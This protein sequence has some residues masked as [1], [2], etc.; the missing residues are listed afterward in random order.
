MSRYH[1]RCIRC[2]ISFLA[3]A[4]MLVC[5][6]CYGNP[7]DIALS[8]FIQAYPD[9]SFNP[10]LKKIEKIISKLENNTCINDEKMS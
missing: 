10:S 3:T 2:Q 7:E 6:H 9:V 8:E 4:N 5:S 1:K